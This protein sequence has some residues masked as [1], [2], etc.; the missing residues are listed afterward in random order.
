VA[1]ILI[2][3]DE[4]AIADTLRY[5]LSADGHQPEW[6]TR[7]HDLLSRMRAA[8]AELVILDV[9]LPDITGFEACR[10]LRQF[11]DVPVIFLTAR[12]DEIDRVVGLE[13]GADDY[14]VKPFSLR[15]VVARV[16]VVLRRRAVPTPV[17][18][19]VPSPQ[20]FHVDEARRCILYRGVA[21]SL[22]PHEYHLL[23]CLLSQPRRVFTRE[24]LLDA[25]GVAND[26]GY[27]RNV[28]GHVKDL[29]AKLRAIDADAEPIQT[30]R[31]FGYSYHPL[32]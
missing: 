14:V 11:S 28:D 18:G 29:R 9:G 1:R 8:P 13:I 17:A 22:T 25:I 3:E 12:G 26:A 23:A 20:A 16:R 21:L 6:I 15:E 31:G 2:V 5:A 4:P 32:P 24:Q 30:H 19:P 7:G 27:A 10:S